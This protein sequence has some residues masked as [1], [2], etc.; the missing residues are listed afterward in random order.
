M[1]S[2]RTAGVCLTTDSTGEAR[3]QAAAHDDLGADS[4]HMSD[5][6]LEDLARM[7]RDEE[8]LP[9]RSDSHHLVHATDPTHYSVNVMVEKDSK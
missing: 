2:A 7:N 8:N 4:W 6:I 5:D 9:E 1:T 3:A